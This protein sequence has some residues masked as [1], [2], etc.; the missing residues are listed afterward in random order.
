M[1][2]RIT[3]FAG[4]LALCSGLTVAQ[5]GTGNKATIASP[6][7]SA[8]AGY[9]REKKSDVCT[10]APRSEWLPEDEMKL[11]AQHRGYRIKTFKVANNSCYEVYGFDREG[12][13]VEAYFNPVTTRLVRQNIAR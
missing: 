4:L 8:T 12:R 9:S 6:G 10:D 3:L 7:A 1:K 13:I 5:T 2:S 11:L